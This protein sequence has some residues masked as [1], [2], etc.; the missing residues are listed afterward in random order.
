M[1]AEKLISEAISL[2]IEK[3]AMIVNSLLQSF[4]EFDQ[5]IEIE[6]IQLARKRLNQIKEN[7][8]DVY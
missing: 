1:N 3:R 4:N 2:P 8:V 6:W 5:K 7:S